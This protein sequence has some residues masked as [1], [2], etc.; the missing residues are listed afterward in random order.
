L[1]RNIPVSLRWFVAPVVDRLS[2]D[3]V[4]ASLRQTRSAVNSMT[5][6]A[7][8]V[9]GG[10]S[11]IPAKGALDAHVSQSSSFSVWRSE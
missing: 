11:T 9:A 4:T 6:V 2:R 7:S 8:R 10:E 1:S 3:S 5:E